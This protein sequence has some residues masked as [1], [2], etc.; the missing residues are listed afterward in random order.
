MGARCK[1][2]KEL[3]VSFDE[4]CGMISGYGAV[5][6]DPSNNRIE[7]MCY[8]NDAESDEIF[9]SWEGFYVID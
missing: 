2:L 9:S 5:I 3:G 7:L 6:R 8:S 1:A 4:M